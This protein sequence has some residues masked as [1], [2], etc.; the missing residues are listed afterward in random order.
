R[1]MAAAAEVWAVPRSDLMVKHGIIAHVPTGR[2]LRYG[3]V[4]E[5]AAAIKLPQEPKIKTPDQFTLMNKPTQFLE[6]PLRV[7]GSVTYGIDVRLPG[8]LYAAAKA[9][10]VFLGKVKK[11]DAAAVKNRPGVHSVVEFGGPDIEAGVAVVADSYWH[12]KTALDLLPIEWNEGAHADDTSEKFLKMA[13]AALDEPGAQVVV[14]KG[15]PGAALK[16]AAKVVEAVYELPYLDHA[17]MEPLNCTAHVT[18]DRV[19]VWVG[20]QRPEEALLD[21]ARLTS[22]PQKDV[23][24]HNCFIGGGFGSC[25]LNAD[26]RQAG[27]VAKP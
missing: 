23:Y 4:A 19:D 6:T 3:Q 17:F 13:R 5:K 2:K 27:M 14:K 24:I 8:M 25:N 26:L 16:G 1:L 9:S 18:A 12:A 11:Y 15:D 20:T 21:A 7:D 22:V 10:P